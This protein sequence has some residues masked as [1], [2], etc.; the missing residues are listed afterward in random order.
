M[1]TSKPQTTPSLLSPDPQPSLKPASNRNRGDRGEVSQLSHVPIRLEWV[2]SQSCYRYCCTINTRRTCIF[3]GAVI[4]T[5]SSCY[6]IP[7]P[8]H[9]SPA[10]SSFGTITFIRIH[11]FILVSRCESVR[12]ASILP[13]PITFDVCASQEQYFDICTPRYVYW[14]TI[15]N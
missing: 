15:G 11:F 4:C 12:I 5:V 2:H 7:L 6:Q 9:T 10:Y 14:S 8:F 3:L 13:F 1:K